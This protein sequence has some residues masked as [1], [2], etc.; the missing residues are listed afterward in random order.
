MIRLM[1]LALGT[2]AG[3]SLAHAGEPV[4]QAALNAYEAGDYARA[5]RLGEEQATAPALAFAAR[6]LVADAISRPDGLC[7]PCLEQA[8]TLARRATARDPRLVEALLQDAIAM[9]L[10]G[11]AMGVEAARADGLAERVRQRLD[12]ALALEPDNLWAR[13]SLGAWHLEITA[14]AGTV[15][16]A[17][18]YDAGPGEG[19]RLYR[20]AV[21]DAGDEAVLPYQFALALL[22]L[23]EKRFA[24]EAER[25]L[26]QAGQSPRRD[27]LSLYI[28]ERAT[29]LLKALRDRPREGLGP[30]V[31]RLQGYPSP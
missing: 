9:G 1:L 14:H 23:D 18:L 29:G 15:L 4:P 21:A 26:L 7:V 25:A 12:A 11:R 2:W 16:A 6:A 20:K 3:L 30:L 17:L 10:R 28:K 22:A 31:A 27:A 19:L 24:P 5:A 13:A 8:E